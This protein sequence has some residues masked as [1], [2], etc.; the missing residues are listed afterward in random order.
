MTVGM[1]G[2]L[3]RSLTWILALEKD[4]KETCLHDHVDSLWTQGM[5]WPMVWHAMNDEQA[6]MNLLAPPLCNAKAS[7][8]VPFQG[9]HAAGMRP[10]GH[11]VK[12]KASL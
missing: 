11:L 3:G 2:K 4:E 1:K 6:T 12:I 5:G 7:P 9:F 10:G 8:L